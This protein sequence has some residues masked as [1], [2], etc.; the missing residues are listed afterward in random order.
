LF[1]SINETNL[2]MI[3]RRPFGAVEP[4]EVNSPSSLFFGFSALSLPSMLEALTGRG[5]VGGSL[6]KL[7]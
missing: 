4:P 5:P 3:I 1:Y 7:L 2:Q 6:V